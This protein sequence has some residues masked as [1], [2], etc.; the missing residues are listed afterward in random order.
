MSSVSYRFREKSQP[1]TYATSLAFDLLEPFP[2]QCILSGSSLVREW[3]ED[4]FRST[5]ALLL[6]EK[7]RVMILAKHH[8]PEV[9]GEKPVWQKERWYKTEHIIRKLHQSFIEA[10][11]QPNT[12]DALH[13]PAP[14]PYIPDN[15]SVDKKEVAKVFQFLL[16]NM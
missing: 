6:P 16:V 13:L 9:V 2:P 14:N 4:L 1:H 12:N 3:D 8:A 10:A 7:C 11:N 15:L 5:L